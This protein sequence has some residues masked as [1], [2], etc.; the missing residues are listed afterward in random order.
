MVELS[1]ANLELGPELPLY[2]PSVDFP[3]PPHSSAQPPDAGGS[4][5]AG[6]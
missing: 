5:W 1:P 2:K 4:L 6:G 3:E